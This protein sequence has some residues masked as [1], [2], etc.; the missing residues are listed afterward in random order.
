MNEKSLMEIGKLLFI[1][2][3]FIAP[4][5]IKFIKKQSDARAKDDR[6]GKKPNVNLRHEIKNTQKKEVSFN[7][8]M[9]DIF[10]APEVKPVRVKSQNKRPKQPYRGPD[11]K[12]I[13]SEN[14]MPELP[15]EK[16]AFRRIDLSKNTVATVKQDFSKGMLLTQSMTN[17]DWKR[18]IIMKEILEPPIALRNN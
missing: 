11:F 9:S 5:I 16:R 15:T 18:A 12:N 10:G 14:L 17:H 6:F 13:D 7:E 2:A 4:I 1:A 8:I 3:I